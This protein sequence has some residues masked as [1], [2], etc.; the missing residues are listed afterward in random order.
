MEFRNRHPAFALEADL[1]IHLPE[2]HKLVI[3]RTFGNENI[4]LHA[5][6]ASHCFSIT[7][8]E[9]IVVYSGK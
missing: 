9:N 4:S 1:Q 6:L 7:E 8:G 3:T 2:T 5:D